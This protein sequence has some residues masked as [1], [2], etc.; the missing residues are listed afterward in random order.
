MRYFS[1]L[2]D[3]VL[4]MFRKDP[5][6]IISSISTL[7]TL[8]RYL[9]CQFC[10]LSASVVSSILTALA[11]SQQNY[12]D[13]NLL[14]VYSVEI[15]LMMDS[16]S[17]RNMQNNLSN[18]YETQCNSLAFIVR[19]YHDARSSECQISIRNIS[20]DWDIMLQVCIQWGMLQRTNVTT[21]SFYKYNQDTT[22]NVVEYYRPTQHAPA[23]DVSDLSA[24]IRAAGIIFVIVCMVQFS[25]QF[26]YLLICTSY[27]N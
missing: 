8:N 5:L 24:L 15:L 17:F 4:Y 26:S 7:Y 1:T 18:K 6:S 2:F 14:S 16:G 20:V 13:K 19:I 27:K 12:H 22:T 11:D 23:H 21:K 3:K 9:S 10:W 25:V